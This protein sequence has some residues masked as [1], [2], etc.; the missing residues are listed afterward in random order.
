MMAAPLRRTLHL[1]ADPPLPSCKISAENCCRLFPTKYAASLKRFMIYGGVYALAG[2][3]YFRDAV[4]CFNFRK[5][6]RSTSMFKTKLR[7]LEHP[8]ASG[9]KQVSAAPSA[10]ASSPPP[11]LPSTTPGWCSSSGL[12]IPASSA[13]RLT[14]KHVCVSAAAVGFL[15]APDAS[16]RAT[17]ATSFNESL[18]H[19]CSVYKRR[20]CSVTEQEAHEPRRAALR[21]PQA[22]EEDAFV[23][24]VYRNICA[25]RWGKR[26]FLLNVLEMSPFLEEWL[27]KNS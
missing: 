9:E 14:L 27:F 19:F 24:F 2:S 21:L 5:V 26:T 8:P 20:R 15:H 1:R 25:L 23:S 11:S 12:L 16:E 10:A 4:V 22:D 18:Q 3:V 17:A 13:D 7:E 6:A